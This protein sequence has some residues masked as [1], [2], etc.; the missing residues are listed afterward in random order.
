MDDG[1]TGTGRDKP[2]K[3]P[4]KWGKIYGKINKN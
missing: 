3:E 4:K 2:T 1:I